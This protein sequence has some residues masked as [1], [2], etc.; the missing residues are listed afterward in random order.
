MGSYAPFLGS[1]VIKHTKKHVWD[2][3][4]DIY[5]LARLNNNLVVA[6]ASYLFH[7][8]DIRKMGTPTQETR[9]RAT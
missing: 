4:K 7:V 3:R 8:Y 1:E 6:M 5:A 9:E 2:G